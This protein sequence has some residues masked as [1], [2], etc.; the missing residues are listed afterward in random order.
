ML[1]LFLKLLKHFIW[2]FFY[3]LIFSTP[4]LGVWL[5]SSLV[6]FINGPT[7]LAVASGILLFP[8][9]PILWDFKGKRKRKNSNLTWGD[10]ITLRT[11]VLNLTFI[12]LLLT[13][14]PET[15]FLALSTRG[16][17]FLDPFQRPEVELVRQ[18]LYRVANTLEWLY[19]SFHN[20]PYKQFADSNTVQPD[21]RD[22]SNPSAKTSDSQNKSSQSENQVWPRKNA[23]LHPAVAKMPSNVETSIESV[24]QYIAKQES[25]PFLRIKALHDY[26]ADR[27][28]YDTE[29]YFAGRYPPQDSQ[30]V[31]QTQKAVCAGY[32][33]LLQALGEAIG[34][35]IFYVSGV[36][37]SSISDLS[38][39]SHAWNATKIEGN[40]YLIDATWDSGF[41]EPSGFTKKYRTEYLFTPP[42]VM[43]ISH[44]PEEQKWQLLSD[45]ISRGEFLRQPMLEPQFFADGLELISPN[46]SQTDTTNEAVIKLKNPNRKW[47][48]AKYTLQEQS[49]SK[50]CTENPTQGTQITCSLPSEGTYRVKLYSGDQQYNHQFDY[51]GQFQF[52]KR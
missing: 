34:E 50:P 23:S 29:S 18:T 7:L 11:L 43:I 5:A 52:N 35:E 22:S 26:V 20:N 3:F 37:R 12:T 30:T 4:L 19:L 44:F 49:Q 14:R 41:V 40:W 17:W 45:P 32:A 39:D 13:L 42:S 8:L 25:D 10:R 9:L 33:N 28:A 38:G 6:A 31:F 51:V 2:L 48:F 27:I 16:D 1:R 24:A 15:S 46:R 47:L 36:S 21:I